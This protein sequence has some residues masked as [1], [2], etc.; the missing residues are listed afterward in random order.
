[1]SIFARLLERV[2]VLSISWNGWRQRKKPR[3]VKGVPNIPERDEDWRAIGE[4]LNGH[5]KTEEV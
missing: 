4:E 1:M 5:R 3:R 2:T